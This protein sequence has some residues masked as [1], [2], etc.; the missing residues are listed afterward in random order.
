MNYQ[1]EPI[2][3]MTREELCN[4]LKALRLTGG[5]DDRTLAIVAQ[6]I[7]LPWLAD[8]PGVR[9]VEIIP[10]GIAACYKQVNER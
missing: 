7:G 5:C 1:D 9:V 6:A 10:I 3:M 2:G 8:E 4:I